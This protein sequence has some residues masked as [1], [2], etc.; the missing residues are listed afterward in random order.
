MGNIPVKVHPTPSNMTDVT[1][2]PSGEVT[3]GNY[4]TF[5]KDAP[6]TTEKVMS[7][8]PG[9]ITKEGGRTVFITEAVKALDADTVIVK[10]PSNPDGFPT[11]T[12]RLAR[13]NA[14][15]TAHPARAATAT[16][17]AKPATPAQPYANEATDYVKKL[18][19]D[20]KISV[21]VTQLHDVFGAKDG[22]QGRSVCELE[23]EGENLN[24]DLLVKGFASVYRTLSKKAAKPSVMDEITEARA[25]NAGVG[26]W[27]P[28]LDA[29]AREDPSVFGK[30]VLNE[31]KDKQNSLLGRLGLL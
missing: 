8:T 18:I 22:K 25:K 31:A 5:P 27:N 15:E 23:V 2:S 12:C 16:E 14:N 21:T 20:K 10:D 28:E 24:T 3:K 17:P 11:L 30:R 29:A 26:R 1:V 19:K 7:A 13:V 4:P 6:K 9:S